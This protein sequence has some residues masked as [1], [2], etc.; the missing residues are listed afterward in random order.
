MKL[1]I[2]IG[3]ETAFVVVSAKMESIRLSLRASDPLTIRQR[4]AEAS[5][6]MDSIF[7]SLRRNKPVSLSLRQAVA[8]AG[9]LYRA[10]ASDP[11]AGSV[12]GMVWSDGKWERDDE[13]TAEELEVAYE[14]TLKRLKPLSGA[15]HDELERAL[16]TLAD[17]M[18]V[19]EGI[20]SLDPSSRR[21]L[22]PELLKAIVQGMEVGER[23]AGGDYRPDPRAERFPEWRPPQVESAEKSQSAASLK[24]LIEAWWREAKAAGFSESTYASYAKAGAALGSFLKHDDATKITPEDIV[25]FKDHLAAS[26]YELSAKTIKDSYL[27]GLRSVFAWAVR[28]RRLPKNPAQGIT[29]KMAK[30]RKL[31][32]TWF[33]AAEITAILGA[34][35]SVHRGPREAG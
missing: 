20:T 18:L 30:R 10:W 12:T 26:P 7:E 35:R 22:L 21:K 5:A 11:D 33:S 17:N 6:Y 29:I 14:T 13:L 4:Q 23:K 34:A 27:A 3:D 31:R 1:A 2:P 9:R 25:A 28:N 19:K 8:L 15:S 24:G 32:D 16:A